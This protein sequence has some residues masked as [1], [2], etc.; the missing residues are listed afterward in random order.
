M[1]MTHSPAFSPLTSRFIQK[2]S[3]CL[4]DI[5]SRWS[6]IIWN[7]TSVKMK[8]YTERRQNPSYGTCQSPS[9]PSQSIQHT[10]KNRGI[11]F[12]L[13]TLSTVITSHQSFDSFF[14]MSE[15]FWPLHAL[16]IQGLVIFKPSS[17]QS[18]DLR[19]LLYRT[20][21]ATSCLDYKFLTFSHVARHT[22]VIPWG[23]HS[24]LR[25]GL[26]LTWPITF[27]LLKA[28]VL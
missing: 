7:S 20:F 28:S 16:L 6:S 22:A 19:R 24:K 14:V 26:F 3:P 9:T 17:C 1:P 5:S 15:L 4:S 23:S 10:A 8:L 2:I 27:K 18:P 13:T 11:F 25:R 21:R 12:A